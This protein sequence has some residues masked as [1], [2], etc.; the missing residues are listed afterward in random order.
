VLGRDRSYFVKHHS[1]STK[2]FSETD[3]FNMLELLIDNI[4]VM[5]EGRVFQQTVDIFMGTNCGPRIADLFLCSHEQ[6]SYRA[7]QE[8]RKEASTIL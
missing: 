3:I 7:S 2:A 4:F 6:T 5:F 1:D 8:K